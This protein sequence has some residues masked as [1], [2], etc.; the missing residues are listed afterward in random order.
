M[1]SRNGIENTACLAA[2]H[3]SNERCTA[4]IRQYKREDVE[5]IAHELSV[6]DEMSYSEF[7]VFCACLA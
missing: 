6:P 7:M 1:A 4:R 5:R 2:R 3:A